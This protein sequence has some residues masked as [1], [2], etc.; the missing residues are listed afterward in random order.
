MKHRLMWA[1]YGF[2]AKPGA[3][4]PEWGRADRSYE[5]PPEAGAP[6]LDRWFIYFFVAK[7]VYGLCIGSVWAYHVG[8]RRP[9][10]DTS[11]PSM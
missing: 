3:K 4:W 9:L 1:K 7:V 10:G 5:N 11:S 8:V 2:P 6:F